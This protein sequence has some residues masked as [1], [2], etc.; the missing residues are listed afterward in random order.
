[1]VD[2][3]R[4]GKGIADKENAK[5][6]GIRIGVFPKPVLVREHANRIAVSRKIAA[7]TIKGKS[8]RC[9]PP[10]ARIGC[11]RAGIR[12]GLQGLIHPNRRFRNYKK[13]R[14]RSARKAD[15]N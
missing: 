1:L 5:P 12:G 8:G 6:L 13:Y 3:L 10:V 4:E 9:A 15:A 14:Q 2:I 7:I 11:Y